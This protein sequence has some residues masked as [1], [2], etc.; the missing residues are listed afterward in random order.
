MTGAGPELLDEPVVE[1]LRPLA[2]EE[3]PHLL[4]PH[5]ELTAVTPLRVLGIDL[6]HPIRVARIPGVL[7]ATDLPGRALCGER[8]NGW[9]SLHGFLRNGYQIPPSATVIA[10]P[11]T[12]PAA[13]PHRNAITCATSRG[14]STRFCG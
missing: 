3:R 7:G 2:L 6:H 11:L 14:S 1:L 9:T 5:G 10:S 12:P 4:A 8:R 13:S